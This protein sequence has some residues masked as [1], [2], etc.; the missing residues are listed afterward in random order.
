LYEHDK[1]NHI[2]RSSLGGFN[3]NAA[4]F[5]AACI[6][7]ALSYIHSLD[8]AYRDLK[9]ENLLV[10][11]SGYLKVIDFGFAKRIPFVKSGKIS[12]KR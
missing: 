12:H 6:I 1:N 10:H 3:E 2:P 5:Y 8:C 4:Q 9:P 7:S 11:S